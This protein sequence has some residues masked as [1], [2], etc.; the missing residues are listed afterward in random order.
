MFRKLSGSN[1]SYTLDLRDERCSGDLGQLELRRVHQQGL[2]AHPRHVEEARLYLMGG[3]HR[4][5]SADVGLAARHHREAEAESGELTAAPAPFG[6][7][8]GREAM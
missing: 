4:Q 5:R 3:R 1:D 8:V 7:G 6:P 2:C